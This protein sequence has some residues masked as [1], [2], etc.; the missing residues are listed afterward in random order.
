MTDTIH[1]RI[2]ACRLKLSL[3]Q[4][5][6]GYKLGL[7][8]TTISFWEKGRNV[9]SGQSLIEL[10][11]IFDCDP[12]WI[13]TGRGYHNA[14]LGQPPSRAEKNFGYYPLMSWGDLPQKK[15]IQDSPLYPC[16]VPCSQSTFALQ[17]KGISM[18]PDLCHNDIIF[19]DPNTSPSSGNY[20]IIHD[21]KKNSILRKIVFDGS[22]SH[23]VASNKE[24]EVNQENKFK[25]LGT[26]ISA[27][28]NV[29]G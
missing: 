4:N 19:V 5:Q 21:D 29:R 25:I 22:Q 20:V 9:P 23:L 3:S 13:L 24:W 12:E 7:S 16:T 10:S 14:E 2:R 26:V 18:E 6:L 15:T 1:E 28:K 8:K 27:I 17:V 11:C